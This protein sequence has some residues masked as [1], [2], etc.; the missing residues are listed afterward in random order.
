MIA[1]VI[2]IIIV[3]SH[4]KPPYS[5]DFESIHQSI[6]SPSVRNAPDGRTMIPT[7]HIL[8]VLWCPRI[9]LDP[10]T[11]DHT[12][13]RQC[14]RKAEPHAIPSIKESADLAYMHTFPRAS[15]IQF[16]ITAAQMARVPGHFKQIRLQQIIRNRH[17]RCNNQHELKNSQMRLKLR[18]NQWNHDI[19]QTRTKVVAIP[20]VSHWRRN[21]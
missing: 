10:K 7:V 1:A 18:S 9:V 21:L 8:A 14:E 12:E 2:K 17:K 4:V 11:P 6:R 19:A 5:F 15:M 20:I 13:Q 16:T 3:S